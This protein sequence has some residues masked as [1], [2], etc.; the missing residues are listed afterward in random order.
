MGKNK[1][2]NRE[3]GLQRGLHRNEAGELKWSRKNTFP[4]LSPKVSIISSQ[5][6]N[7]VGRQLPLKSCLLESGASAA[8]S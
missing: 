8:V 6:G 2:G 5:D 7:K 4:S 1:E 3:E